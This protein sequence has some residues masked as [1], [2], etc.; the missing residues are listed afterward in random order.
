MI[1]AGAAK[2]GTFGVPDLAPT[3]LIG[4]LVEER[5]QLQRR[6][7]LIA[8]GCLFLVVTGAAVVSSMVRSPAAVAA[9]AIVIAIVWGA[10]GRGLVT[11][12]RS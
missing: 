10:V 3:R 12:E 11:K 7:P 5:R 8:S 4:W 1:R 2:Q 9:V 6:L